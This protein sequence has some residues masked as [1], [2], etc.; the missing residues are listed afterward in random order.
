[1]DSITVLVGRIE[2]LRNGATQD[3]TRE[4]QFEG[5]ELATY[6]EYGTNDHGKL[7]DTRGVAETL[8]RTS[9][10]RLVV[11]IE[12]WS[13]WQGEP[14]TYTLQEVAEEDLAGPQA[15]YEGL[16]IEAGLSRPLTLDEA[17]IPKE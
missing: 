14:T 5:E 11:H 8:Y 17:L 6:R 7:T 10:G 13:H 4:V 15:L 2:A 16:G 1:M 12:D 9:D 3:L